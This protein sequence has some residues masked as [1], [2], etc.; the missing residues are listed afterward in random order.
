MGKYRERSTNVFMIGCSNSILHFIYLLSIWQLCG[1]MAEDAICSTFN[2]SMSYGCLDFRTAASFT[3]EG[4]SAVI[5]PAHQGRTNKQ[6]DA[7]VCSGE[8]EKLNWLQLALI[9]RMYEG[10]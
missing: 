2:F 1:C 9:N 6:Y 8:L 4:A 5:S 7:Q 3:E 10:N